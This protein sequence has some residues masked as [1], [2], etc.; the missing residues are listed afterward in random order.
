[1]TASCMMQKNKQLCIACVQSISCCRSR[2][3]LGLS[4]S[5][6]RKYWKTLVI[7]ISSSELCEPDLLSVLWLLHK[8]DKLLLL[9]G[10]PG[11]VQIALAT[12]ASLQGHF[13]GCW[14]AA[15]LGH[16]QVM[17]HLNMHNKNWHSESVCAFL[18]AASWHPH[19][20]AG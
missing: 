8:P 15:T 20:R 11:L 3:G 14:A 4:T 6:R 7:R 17:H 5:S 9:C 18:D 13:Q 10:G 19:R 2:K 16:A 1:M 12:V